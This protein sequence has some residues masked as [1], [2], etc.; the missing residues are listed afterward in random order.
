L[1]GSA[2]V[3]PPAAVAASR[4]RAPRAADVAVAAAVATA[5]V[6]VEIVLRAYLSRPFWYDEIWRAHFVSEPLDSFWPELARA[7]TPSAAGWLG[8]TRLAGELFGWHTWALR[9]PIFAALP[10]LGAGTYLLARRFT[11]R[12]A[13]LAAAA[14]LCL[15]GTVLDLGTQLKPYTVEA[16]AAVAVVALW[17]PASAAS[18]SEAASSAAAFSRRLLR[19]TGAGLLSLLAVPL[20]FLL[21]ALAAADVAAGP[22][23]GRGSIR[24]RIGAALA[25]L[26]AL[27]LAAAHTALFVGHQSSQRNGT[28][29]DRNFLA[30]RGVW[31][32]VA[33]VG[34]QLHAGAAGT[35]PGVDRFDPSLVH[36][37]S[38]GT[39]FADWV[40]APAL[41]VAFAAGVVVLARR[42][43]GR[44]L[45]AGLFGAE[46][47]MLAASA[48]RYWPFGPT[49]TNLFVVPFIVI[50]VVAGA[51]APARLLAH[52]LARGFASALVP[53]ACLVAVGGLAL[54]SALVP[55]HAVWEHRDRT[56]G[57]DHLGDAAFA[58]RRLAQPGDLVVVG[59]R[60]VRPGW[61]YVMEESD[62]PPARTAAPPRVWRSQTVFVTVMG[63]GSLAR[64]IGDRAERAGQASRPERAVRAERPR[65]ILLF[66]FDLDAAGGRRDLAELRREGWCA[67]AA[68]EFR[69][70]GT[71]HLLTRCS[72]R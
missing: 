21:L 4:P 16:A 9:L 63:D 64:Q 46:L 1:T 71:L 72:A 57:L 26:P 47:L 40:L 58:V 3:S 42:A 39:V 23:R 15:G 32:A 11:G 50:V 19:R 51:A 10:A 54:L 6:V 25:A 49:R 66:V 44:L 69:L 34:A 55:V 30:G 7:N 41:A 61:I 70:T 31:D 27:A 22:R 13:A 35:P 36:P 5:L 48:L 45:L 24:I 37:P 8:V 14:W 38:D 59:G 68:W 62:D 67:E 43:D 20:A 53:L 65:R 12:A 33:F 17:M 28:Y 60:L 29:W 56:R 2:R 52:R 18:S